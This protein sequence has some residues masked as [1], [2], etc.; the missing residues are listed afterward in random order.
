[1]KALQV[2]LFHLTALDLL[3]KQISVSLFSRKDS[4]VLLAFPTR[5][6]MLINLCLEEEQSPYFWPKKI[7]LF[8]SIKWDRSHF[9]EPYRS[10]GSIE[11]LL[12]LRQEL[13]DWEHARIRWAQCVLLTQLLSV[14]RLH[15]SSH[16]SQDLHLSQLLRVLDR[17]HW[18][19]L[20]LPLWANFSQCFYPNWMPIRGKCHVCYDFISSGACAKEHPLPSVFAWDLPYHGYYVKFCLMSFNPNAPTTFSAS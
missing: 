20:I 8:Q 17:V 5:S 19:T 10:Y 18:M 4:F 11:R 2:C 16:S 3:Q 6:F 15:A 13:S 14:I 12:L 7:S 1:M 9:G